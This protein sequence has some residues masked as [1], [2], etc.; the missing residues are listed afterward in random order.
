MIIAILAKMIKNNRRRRPQGPAIFVFTIKQPKRIVLQTT[1]AIF[2]ELFFQR[3]VI[4]QEFFPIVGTA[5]AATDS[6]DPKIYIF[7]FQQIKETMNG[8]NYLSVI[9]RMIVG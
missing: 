1:L 6:V 9:N 4:F 5:D 2:T 3:P 7:N 8:K